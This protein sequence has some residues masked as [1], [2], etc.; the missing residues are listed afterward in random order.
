MIKRMQGTLGKIVV[1]GRRMV[2]VA[3][4]PR[5]G[6]ERGCRRRRSIRLS[7]ILVI[8][9]AGSRSDST[10]FDFSQVF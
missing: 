2:L 3:A 5:A 6:L 1:L 10:A 7:V 8:D 4:P 9:L